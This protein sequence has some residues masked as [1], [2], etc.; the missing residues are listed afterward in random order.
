MKEEKERI[1]IQKKRERE[2]WFGESEERSSRSQKK[3]KVE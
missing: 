1:F 3:I 2:D